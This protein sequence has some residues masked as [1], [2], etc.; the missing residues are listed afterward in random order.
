MR[1]N[2][3]VFIAVGTPPADDGSADLRHVEEAARAIARALNGYK[4][5]V[6]KSTVPV[7]TG[8]KVYGVD[9]GGACR[10]GRLH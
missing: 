10:A 6:D 4:V 1:A 7:G 8:R 2:E 9:R 3:V 5:I